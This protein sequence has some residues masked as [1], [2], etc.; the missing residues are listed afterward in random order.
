MAADLVGNGFEAVAEL[1]DL[2]GQPGESVG[3]VIEVGEGVGAPAVGAR[4]LV[5]SG[6]GGF[7]TEIVAPADRVSIVPPTPKPAAG[8]ARQN[9]TVAS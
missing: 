5:T 4:V 3:V 9:D 8:S 7:A 2:G 6:V 1:L